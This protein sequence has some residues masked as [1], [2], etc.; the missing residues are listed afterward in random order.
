MKTAGTS[1]MAMCVYACKNNKGM[2]LVD[3]VISCFS[4]S[5]FDTAVRNIPPLFALAVSDKTDF[6]Q[7]FAHIKARHRY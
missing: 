7:I 2:T 5:L 3:F 6:Q 1:E 4:V